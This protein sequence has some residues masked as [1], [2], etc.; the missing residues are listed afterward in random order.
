MP[1]LAI[2]GSPQIRDVDPDARYVSAR[3]AVAPKRPVKEPPKNPPQGPKKDP[4]DRD[5][6]VKEPP[7]EDPTT[8]GGLER[9]LLLA[10]SPPA[11]AVPQ[12]RQVRR[13]KR[14]DA[15]VYR[16]RGASGGIARR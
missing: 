13:D 12:A 1:R 3:A 11:P 16:G 5:P 8:P 4:P 2:I 6:P 9:F 14:G 15:A 7:D 10:I